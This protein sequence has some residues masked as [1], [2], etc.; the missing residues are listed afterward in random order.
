MTRYPSLRELVGPHGRPGRVRK[1][2][3]PPIFD[4]RAVHPVAIRTI[5]IMC[6]KIVTV[7]SKILRVYN[8][9]DEA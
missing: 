1:I 3:L 5:E 7:L 4:P 6:K 9:D 2:S 8:E